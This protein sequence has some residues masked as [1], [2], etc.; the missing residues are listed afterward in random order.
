MTLPGGPAEKLGNRYERWWTLSE[1][2]R[3]LNGDTEALRIEDPGIDKAEFVVTTGSHRELHQAKRSHPTGKWTLQRLW[4]EGLVQAAGEQLAGNDDRFVFVSSSDAPELRVLCDA[5]RDAESDDEFV[6]HFLKARGRKQGFERLRDWWQCDVSAA[7]D[8]LHRIDVRIIDERGL[9][10]QVTSGVHVLFLGEPGPVVA[11]LRRIAEDTVHQTWTRSTLLRELQKHGY[12]PSRL[13]RPESAGA[14]VEAATDRYLDLV[15]KRLIRQ[16]LVPNPAVRTLLSELGGIATDRVLTGRAGSGK[17]ACVIELVDHI[18]D[19][20]LPV[21]ALRLDRVQWSSTTKTTELGARL[22]LEGS[23]VLVLAAAAEAA[24]RP[25]VFVVDQLD[26]VSTISGRNTEALDLVEDL[27]REVRVCRARCAIHTVVVCR[28]FDWENDSRLR[29]LVPP[30]SGGQLAIAEFTPED[31]KSILVSS[32]FDTALLAP[33]QVALLRLPQNLSLFLEADF[34]VSSAPV[35]DTA[36]ALFDR[37]WETKR[38]SVTDQVPTVQEQWVDVIRILCDEMTIAQQ[39][40]VSRESLDGFPQDYIDAMASEGVLTFDGRRYGF[41]HESFFDYC[42]ARLFVT[43]SQSMVSFLTGSEQHLFRR[44]QVR[45]VLGYLRD[46]R[47]GRYVRELTKLLSEDRIRLHL[48]ELAIALLANVADPTEDEWS[49]WE[50]WLDSALKSLEEGAPNTNP[51]SELAWRKFF[52]SSSWFRSVEARGLISGWLSSGNDRIADMAVTYLSVHHRTAPDRVAAML[53]PYADCGGHWSVRLRNFMQR[54]RFQA[55]RRLFDLFLRLVKNGTLDDVRVPLVENTTFWSMIYTPSRARPELFPEVL[56]HRLRRRLSIIQATGEKLG[57]RELLGYDS[58]LSSMALE[59]AAKAP[60]VCVEHLLPVVLEISDAAVVGD[61]LPRRDAVWRYRIKSDHPSGVDACLDAVAQALGAFAREGTVDLSDTVAELRHRDTY[62]ADL[63]LLAL[64]AGGCERYANEAATLFCDEPWRFECGYSDNPRWCAIETIQAIFPHC[65]PEVRERFESVVLEYFPP[66]ERSKNGYRLS[67]NAQFSLLSAIPAPLRSARGSARVAELER[68]FREPEG[69]PRGSIGGWIRPPIESRGIARMTDDDWLRAIATYSGE[70]PDHSTFPDFKGGAGELAQELAAR[71]REEP[72]RFARLSLRFPSDANPVYLDQTLVALKDASVETDLKLQ[73]C[74]KAFAEAPGRC[75]REIAGLLG[76]IEDP[77]P[78]DAI[79]MLH[80]LMTEHDDPTAELWQEYVSSG[81]E[82]LHKKMTD[83]GLQSTRGG[84][85]IAITALI[86]RDPAYIDR[87]RRTLERMV[88]DRIPAVLSWVAQTLR[89]VAF[90]DLDLALRLFLNLDVSDVRLLATP[91]VR[92][93]MS[94]R[95][96]DCFDDLRSVL[97]RMLR[98]S[99]PKVSEVGARLASLAH[100]MGQDAGDLVEEALRG[101]PHQRLG[102]A[103]VAAANVANPECRRWSLGTLPALFNDD[104]AEVR[105]EAASCFQQLKDEGLDMYEG[106]IAGFCDSRAV[107]GESYWLLQ[108]LE[109]SL[110]RLPGLTCRVCEQLLD[111][112]AERTAE[113]PTGRVDMHT[114]AKIVFRTYQ[115]HQDDDWT[116]RALDLVDRLC[117]EG[118]VDAASHLGE[119][120][121]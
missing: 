26:A 103:R 42:F 92:G 90:H 119:F 41:G 35:F 78:D 27:M 5:A 112:L 97:E 16:K 37:Y 50:A 83:V 10:D 36:K 68:K 110:S 13:P 54:A 104:A 62:I 7:R 82:D 64:Y 73:V 11:E 8:R 29:Q 100:L 91:H 81:G 74:R 95:L 57:K 109:D 76:S 46:A 60:A 111:Q 114:L 88:R 12:L 87:F 118:P 17:T 22:D 101:D 99:E 102:V 28:A 113:I 55:S 4:T 15:R 108:L 65:S 63:L 56:A 6:R 19:Q 84:V 72:D 75:G 38:R 98:S 117:L 94:E 25:G 66:F 77:L 70:F 89:V 33:R 18:R 106:L 43:G 47:R 32:G 96:E 3:L 20:G 30:N 34:D 121:R 69:E 93:F 49:V 61:A 53:E 67:G 59:S 1:L 14:A 58:Y 44:A 86:R 2:V 40:S 21:L 39:L 80:W 24:G 23:P 116:S 79:V 45:Q 120:E 51:V 9:V 105:R 52:G 71:V 48:K 85:A 115:Q 107:R 31:V